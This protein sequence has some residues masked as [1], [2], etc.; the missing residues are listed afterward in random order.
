VLAAACAR[1][2][3]GNS[4]GPLGMTRSRWTGWPLKQHTGASI[5]AAGSHLLLPARHS[6]TRHAYPSRWLHLDSPRPAR[7]PV[8]PTDRTDY[9]LRIWPKASLSGMDCNTARCGLTFNPAAP[10][11]SAGGVSARPTGWPPT[12]DWVTPEY[13]LCAVRVHGERGE[14]AGALPVRAPFPEPTAHQ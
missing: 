2:L 6:R 7:Q 8:H 3:A 10:I 5:R 9:L 13:R 14:E 4:C 11:Y 1:C 12:P